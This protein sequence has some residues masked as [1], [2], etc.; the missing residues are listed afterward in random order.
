MGLVESVRIMGVIEPPV[1]APQGEL[2]RCLAGERRIRAALAAGLATIPVRIIRNVEARDAVLALQLTENNQ[3]ADLDA[4]D[5]GAAYLEFFRVRHGELTVE[6]V[7]NHLITY[8]RDPK[9]VKTEIA[10][11]VSAIVK[12]L[13]KSSRSLQ[14]IISLQIL[15]PEAREAVRMKKL[16][17]SQ[18]Y[19]FADNVANP[20]FAEILAEALN[21]NMSNETLLKRF[22]EYGKP[23]VGRPAQP[24]AVCSRSLNDIRKVIE[25]NGPGMTAEDL[26]NLLEEIKSVGELVANLK[27]EVE[28]AVAAGS[29]TGE[30]DSG[31]GTETPVPAKPKKK[32]V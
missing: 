19:I 29:G 2:Y 9:R 6:E 30:G 11:T 10:E 4:L 21:G 32:I 5:Q 25:E 1:V 15:P 14:N 22:K 31:Q 16:T 23:K 3:R 20:G 13:G 7:L 24:V 12:I 27:A 17:V 28:A 26:F 8:E 18:G